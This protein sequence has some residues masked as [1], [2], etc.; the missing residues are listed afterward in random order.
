MLPASA[1]G[2]TK[3]A[4]HA[5]SSFAA[6]PCPKPTRSPLNAPLQERAERAR[7][8]LEAEA[9]AKAAAAAAAGSLQPRVNFV[10]ANARSV[11]TQSLPSSLQ[12]TARVA[13][14]GGAAQLDCRPH[15]IRVWPGVMRTVAQGQG[16]RSSRA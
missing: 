13:S 7:V 1:M 8:E 14:Q 15:T 12:V 9:E 10:A 3:A 2:A 11:C 5:A 6:V 4:A 16:V